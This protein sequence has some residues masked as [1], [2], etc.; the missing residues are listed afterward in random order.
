V[1]AA[2]AP[3]TSRGRAT[4]E[5]IVAAAT[6]VI[7]R[8]GV[9]ATSLD[10]VRAVASVSKSQLYHYFA[11]KD[12]LVRAVVAAAIDGVLGGQPQLADLSSWRMISAWFDS[13]V[14]VQVERHAIGGCPIGG[15]VGELADHDDKA[16]VMLAGGYARWEAPLAR[17]LER[18]QA[19]GRLRRDAN[20]ARLAT[21]TL[22]SMQGGLVLTQARRDPEQLRIALDAALAHLRSFRP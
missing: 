17:G 13:L 3:I 22:A 9:A 4:R 8:R 12:A 19:R 1:P 15:L 2:D 7:V 11:D 18:M 10:D 16:Q 20:P 21:A 5:R 14:A 6:E